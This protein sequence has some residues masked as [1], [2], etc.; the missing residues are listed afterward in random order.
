MID[1]VGLGSEHDVLK[2]LG[3]ARLDLSSLSWTESITL[4]LQCKLR[5]RMA[6]Q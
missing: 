3:E 6:D 2:F 4:C 1:D 5:N